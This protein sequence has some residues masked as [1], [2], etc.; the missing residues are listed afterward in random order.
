METESQILERSLAENDFPPPV[1]GRLRELLDGLDLASWF[2]SVDDSAYALDDWLRGLV[3]FDDWLTAQRV[4]ERP[5]ATMLGYLECCTL[6]V[7]ETLAPPDFA[8][9]VRSNLDTYG[10]DAARPAEA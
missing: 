5:V 7:P 8:D 10:F 9:L 2:E 1:A 3:A 6:T 4:A